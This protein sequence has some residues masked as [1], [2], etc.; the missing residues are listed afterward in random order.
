MRIN[1][2]T[3]AYILFALAIGIILGLTYYT[4]HGGL[5]GP[6]IL[7]DIHNIEPAQIDELSIESIKQVI[8]HNSSGPLGRP[9]STLSFSL[10]GY[11]T[12]PSAE[13]FKYHNLMIHLLNGLLLFWLGGRILQNIIKSDNVKPWIIAGLAASIWLLHPLQISTVLYA[14]QRMA[15]LAATFTIIS[16]LFYVIG[17]QSFN[18]KKS[19]SLLCLYLGL[20]ASI[21]CAIFSKENG[22]LIPFYLFIIEAFIFRFKTTQRKEKINLGIVSGLFIALPIILGGIYFILKFDS[23]TDYSRRPFTLSQRL[24]T[25]ANVLIFYVKLILL[26]RLA[27][28]GLFHDDFAIKSGLDAATAASIG[29]L[30]AALAVAILKREKAPALSLGITWFLVSHLL[31]STLLPLELVF[32][33]RNYLALFGLA[34]IFSY[35][36]T[37]LPISNIRKGI[38]AVIPIAMLATLSTVR[39]NTWS[40]MELLTTISVNDHPNSARARTFLANA[41]LEQHKNDEALKQLSVARSIIPSDAGPTI[42]SA[43]VFCYSPKIPDE[44]LTEANNRLRS[45]PITPYALNGINAMANRSFIGQCPSLDPDRLFDLIDSALSEPDNLSNPSILGYLYRLQ[46]QAYMVT[47]DMEKAFQAYDTAYK[48]SGDPDSI[49]E[50]I[51]AQIQTNN[52]D[53]AAASLQ[54]LHEINKHSKKNYDKILLDL[55]KI[56]INKRKNNDISSH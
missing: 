14:V 35:Y 54:E 3:L 38:I 56:I 2:E 25:E 27:D 50:K 8:T 49:Q 39:A 24:L 28:M 46:A 12:G 6:F 55:E 34:F 5:A 47:G 9:I 4:Y 21:L 15:Q 13:G 48:N 43:E 36:L 29:L 31:E 53:A 16:C 11:F 52:L 30:I 23:L 41:L 7:D 45:Y 17:R 40:G 10:S 19:A 44:L 1:R 32:E 22:A 42:H 20:P 18:Q 37:K 26:P 51:S 33:H